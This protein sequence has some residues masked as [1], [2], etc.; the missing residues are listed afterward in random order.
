M[1]YIILGIPQYSMKCKDIN[2]GSLHSKS[3]RTGPLLAVSEELNGLH[4]QLAG[5]EI[6]NWQRW[7]RKQ[8]ERETATKRKVY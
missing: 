4:L 2:V 8:W 5:T 3:S 7:E 1:S 6:P